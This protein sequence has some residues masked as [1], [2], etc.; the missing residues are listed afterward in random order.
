MTIFGVFFDW[1]RLTRENGV[2]SYVGLRV[3]RSAMH[4]LSDG[5]SELV[6]S[7][8]NLSSSGDAS[9]GDHIRIELSNTRPRFQKFKKNSDSVSAK[10][11]VHGH[12]TQLE[13]D[14]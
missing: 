3:S 11:P 14:S 1:L 5:S 7:R 9:K 13:I 6:L 12:D 2:Y 10:I 8:V 4:S